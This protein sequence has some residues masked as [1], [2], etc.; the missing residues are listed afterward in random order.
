M[1]SVTQL[2]YLVFE[3]SDLSK[4]EA[5]GRDILGLDPVRN[6]DGSLS[7]RM[8]E[9]SQRFLLLPGPA[10]DLAG[11]GWELPTRAA[12]D[13]FALTLEAQGMPLVEGTF[14]EAASRQV[15][16]LYRGTDPSGNPLEFYCGPKIAA[17]SFASGAVRS[18]FNTGDEGL[19]HIIVRTANLEQSVAFYCT[20]L[21]LRHSD[22]IRIPISSGQLDFVFLHANRRHHS[23]AFVDQMLPKRIH[24]FMIE[25]NVL[26][27]VGQAFDRC[28][29]AG[30]P[31]TRSLGR[32]PND[33]MFSFYGQTPSG[34]Q[35]ELGWAG[36]KIDDATWTTSVY[37][38][39]SEWGHR[40]PPGEPQPYGQLAK[41][42]S[43]TAARP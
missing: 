7:M 10:D 30:V 28:N 24:H 4:W 11:A 13:A 12:L 14:D 40:P 37:S 2:G 31:I 41:S 35:F 1:P 25:V 27:D 8:D 32:H 43:A 39:I 6:A 33:R 23:V 3:A 36:R 29:D 15:E 19:G 34:F 16:K 20:M 21:G 18:G 9:H 22:T 42:P 38:Q 17:D 5:F 26:D